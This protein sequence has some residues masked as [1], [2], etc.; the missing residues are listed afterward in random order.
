MIRL[1]AIGSLEIDGGS[2]SALRTTIEA[3]TIARKYKCPTLIHSGPFQR[4]GGLNSIPPL[5][6]R[7]DLCQ[8]ESST[9]PAKWATVFLRGRIAGMNE[10]PYQSPEIDGKAALKIKMRRR[11]LVN[12]LQG[13]GVAV[14]AFV[15]FWLPGIARII[16]RAIFGL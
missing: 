6:P 4:C 9:S 3:H 7:N 1:A 16:F 8:I 12:L 2:T 14:F 11:R 15:L 10:N 5:Y 13:I